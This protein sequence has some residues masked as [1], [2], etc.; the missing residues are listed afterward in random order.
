M[1][2]LYQQVMDSIH[3]GEP[4]LIDGAT[5]TEVE[6]RGVPKLDNVW[7]GGGILS[8]P[9]IVQ[10]IHEDYIR[11]G[12]RMVISNTFATHRS[13][14]EGG[15]VADQFDAFNHQA[16]TLARAAR[17]RLNAHHVLVAGGMSHW[18]F[19]KPEPSI[20]RLHADATDQARIMADAGADLLV[21]EM[22]AEIEPMMAL[23][24]G[25]LRTQL[26]VWVG[27]SCE[28]DQHSEVILIGGERLVDAIAALED[29]DVPLLNIMHTDVT[30]VSRCLDVLDRCWQ[31]E[32]GVYAHS[33]TV[34]DGDW[35]FNDI[36]SH[37]D[38]ARYV[39]EWLA[40]D[41][42]LIGGCCGI[43]PDH[44]THLAC[45]EHFNPSP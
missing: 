5:G 8:H 6:R 3:R 1:G 33:G 7:N 18:S 29:R 14:L 45:G 10:E 9:E 35:I 24:D 31:G 40:R 42:R 19:S 20:A 16:V 25:A 32:V 15:G 13:A 12:A 34:K 22:M 39:S 28:L 27:L 44:I 23:L 41:V 21:L 4:F 36:I 2:D 17:D 30:I 26:P 11:C 43:G 38:Y 37:E